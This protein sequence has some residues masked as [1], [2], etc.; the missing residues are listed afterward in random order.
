ME[1]GKFSSA[2]RAPP[3]DNRKIFCAGCGFF[4]YMR[5][6]GACAVF[7]KECLRRERRRRVRAFQPC[8]DSRAGCL[9]IWACAR[10]EAVWRRE[11][12]NNAAEKSLKIRG[13]ATRRRRP[14]LWRAGAV[15]AARCARFFL[16]FVRFKKT[17]FAPHKKFA[18]YPRFCLYQKTMKKFAAC[19]CV[20]AAMSCAP[21]VGAGEASAPTASDVVYLKQRISELEGKLK[22]LNEKYAAAIES[23]MKM[24]AQLR[25][26]NRA[27]K[28]RL[29]GLQRARDS[30]ELDIGEIRE[31]RRA[32]RIQALRDSDDDSRETLDAARA[33]AE[34]A[35]AE[36]RKAQ[37]QVQAKAQVRKVS[38]EPSASAS[39]VVRADA[40]SRGAASAKAGEEKVERMEEPAPAKKSDSIWDNMFPF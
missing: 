30:E 27:L 15:C 1:C 24:L 14:F 18:L 9:E 35:A 13:R 5:V 22:E 39:E 11:K 34:E 20:L 10:G 40:S 16:A 17:I 36:T 29:R 3:R 21:L 8:S 25:R 2:G 31:A 19:V 37:A 38:A 7:S 4:I 6:C 33:R 32:E 12:R 23:D 26:E 28:V